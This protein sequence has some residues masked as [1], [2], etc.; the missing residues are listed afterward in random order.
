MLNKLSHRPTFD[1]NPKLS[2]QSISL[3]SLLTAISQMEIPEAQ[4]AKTNEIIIGINNFSGSDPELLKVMKV[5]QAAILKLLETELKITPQNHFQTLWLALGMAAF[6]IP[7]GVAFGAAMGNMGLLALGIPI[8]MSFGI[9]VGTSLDTKAKNEG[10]QL[11]WK[12]S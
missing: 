4:L 1:T 5:G 2:K 8:G 3:Q 12:V 9:A 6:G 7:L 10:R 11:D